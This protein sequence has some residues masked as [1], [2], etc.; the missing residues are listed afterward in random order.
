MGGATCGPGS[1]A[2]AASFGLASALSVVVLGDESGYSVGYSQKMKLAA[3]EGM[4][5]TQPAP[6]S[7]ALFGIPDQA[8]INRMLEE[9]RS[10]YHC[11]FERNP[12]LC[13]YREQY[14]KL[15]DDVSSLCKA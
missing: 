9:D 15:H 12:F 10:C 14:L 5:E 3:I 8:Y 13:Q 1:I 6:A 7:F 4:W 11:F 2:V